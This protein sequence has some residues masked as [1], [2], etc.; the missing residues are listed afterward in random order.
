MHMRFR[1][2]QANLPLLVNCTLLKF[3]CQAALLPSALLAEVV[4]DILPF[5]FE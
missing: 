1:T 2:R 4:I 3:A 5:L